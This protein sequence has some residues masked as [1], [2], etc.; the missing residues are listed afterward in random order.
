MG[1]FDTTL[2][3]TKYVASLLADEDT[4]F[5]MDGLLSAKEP[6]KQEDFKVYL[7][8]LPP[9]Y[10][11]GGYI[12]EVFSIVSRHL[13]ENEVILQIESATTK[14]KYYISETLFELNYKEMDL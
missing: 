3:S 2:Q 5:V 9:S 8:K 12:D 6:E 7:R 14:E 11:E 13:L 1:N 4:M 10:A